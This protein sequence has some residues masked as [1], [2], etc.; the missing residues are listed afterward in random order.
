MKIALCLFGY[1]KGSTIFAGGAYQE[2]FKHLF[3]QVMVHDPDVFIHSWDESLEEEL[4]ELFNPKESIFEPQKKFTD[5]ILS[6]DIQRFAAGRGCAFKTTSF[7]YTRK[8]SNDL[9][10][11][12]ENKNGFKYDCV[13]S[14]RFD[15]G[16]HNHGKNKTSYMKF[17]PNNNMNSVYSAYWDQIN[18][19]LSDHWFYSNSDN[20]NVVSSMCDDVIEYLSKD[21]EY[22]ETM[23]D[24]CF[25][26]NAEDW[27]S[28]EFLKNK[29]EKTSNLHQYEES[30]CLNNHC[31]YKWH[32]HKNNLWNP[33]SCK[34]LNEELW[35]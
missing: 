32:L 16:Y 26:T 7:L 4:I 31:L 21:S 27:F 12:Y 29:D 34:F 8:M 11:E 35:K 6:M 30:Y 33:E 9:K 15:V 13:V 14:S 3:E 5:E 10:T 24:G 2:K 28:N 22:I 23:M 19:G 17:D 20:M 1:P 25:D 18:A